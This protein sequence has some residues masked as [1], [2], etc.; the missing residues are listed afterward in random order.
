MVFEILPLRFGEGFLVS[1]FTLLFLYLKIHNINKI[2]FK[3]YKNIFI[4]TLIFIVLSKNMIRI[5]E[6]YHLKYTDYPWPKKNSYSKLN[7]LNEYNKIMK[8][9]K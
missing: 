8:M 1:F 3:N 9:V 6:N 5:Y 4:S 7:K 2:N